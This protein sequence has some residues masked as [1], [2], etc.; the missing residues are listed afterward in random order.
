MLK[1]LSPDLIQRRLTSLF[2]GELIEDIARE[3]DVVQR[4]RRIDVTALVW[5]LILGFA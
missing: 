5:T 4:H 2:P 1:E 3:R